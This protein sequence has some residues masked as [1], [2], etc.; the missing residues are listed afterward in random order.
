MVTTS[1]RN[2]LAAAAVAS[3]AAP[4]A[5]RPA[6][7]AHPAP[8]AKPGPIALAAPADLGAAVAAV[9]KATGAAAE[10][11]PLGGVPL[12][13]GRSFEVDPAVAERLLAGSHETFKKAGM[14]L[15]RYERSYGMPG[16]KDKLGLI[17]TGDYRAVIRKVGT[18]QA[19]RDLSTQKLISWLEALA[20]DEPF[21]LSEI[22][23]DYLAGRFDQTPKDAEAVA[24]RCAEIAPDL[25][26]GRAST[27]SLL[28][29]EIKENRTLYLIW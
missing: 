28:A 16:D 11:F 2:V 25:V 3:L 7:T 9:V 4:S 5:V 8:A 14:Y 12:A 17:A 29:A 15:F 18:G 20:K 22:G 10:K 13:E 24:K 21:D 6:E 26:A 23:T 1:I 19:R 27:L